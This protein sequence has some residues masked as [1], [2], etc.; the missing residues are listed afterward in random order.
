MPLYIA[1]KTGETFMHN[2]EDNDQRDDFDDFRVEITDLP[3][4]ETP[5][6]SSVLLDLGLRFFSRVRTL[7]VKVSWQARDDDEDEDNDDGD[8]SSF[9]LRVSDLPPEETTSISGKL[10]DTGKRF[11]P[12]RRHISHLT[13]LGSVLLVLIL[14]FISA[15]ASHPCLPTPQPVLSCR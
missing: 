4:E 2:A 1:E 13:L 11:W 5:G 12:L 8:D 7:N 10:L 9:D 15:T 3:P 14:A 6:I